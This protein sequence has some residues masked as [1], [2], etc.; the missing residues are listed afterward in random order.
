M[1]FLWRCLGSGCLIF[2]GFVKRKWWKK[3]GWVLGV[4]FVI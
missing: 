3:S 2:I 1:I 4:V